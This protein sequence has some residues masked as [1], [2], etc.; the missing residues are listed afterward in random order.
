MACEMGEKYS[1]VTGRYLVSMFTGVEWHKLTGNWK[2]DMQLD[3]PSGFWFITGIY[4]ENI[5]F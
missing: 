1:Q 2:V 5:R 4:V 3:N